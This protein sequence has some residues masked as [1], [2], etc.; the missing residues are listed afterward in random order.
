MG[1]TDIAQ[2]VEPVFLLDLANVGGGIARHGPYGC[3]GQRGGTADLRA[4][5]SD[6][7][8]RTL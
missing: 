1:L 2:L 7:C 6:K 5:S 8:R 4:S 3:K